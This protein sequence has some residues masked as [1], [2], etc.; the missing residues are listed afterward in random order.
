[1]KFNTLHLN[2]DQQKWALQVRQFNYLQEIQ[3]DK[4]NKLL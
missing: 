2:F 3:S 4:E 1:M